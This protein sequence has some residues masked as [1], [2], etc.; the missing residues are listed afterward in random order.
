ME[1]ER[2][3]GERERERQRSAFQAPAIRDVEEGRIRPEVCLASRFVSFFVVPLCTADVSC[4]SSQGE[5]RNRTD[6]RTGV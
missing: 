2:E 6:G 5:W 3:R 1:K 4:V